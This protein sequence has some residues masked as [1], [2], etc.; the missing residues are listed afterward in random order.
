M[1]KI[2]LTASAVFM[3]VGGAAALFAP[4]EL[5]TFLTIPRSGAAMLIIQL[6]AATLVAFALANWMAKD[7]RMG[8]IYNRPLALANL[9]HFAVGAITFIKAFAAGTM[10]SA[11]APVALCYCALALAFVKIVF[12]PSTET[13]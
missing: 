13:A 9:L 1:T 7:S 10:P 11:F 2:L 12:R 6:L 4:Q 8:G 5:L 3:A